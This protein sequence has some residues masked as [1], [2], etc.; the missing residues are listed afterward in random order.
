MAVTSPTHVVSH[1]TA[2]QY[3]SW[4]QRLVAHGSHEFERA[5]PVAQ[6][7][8]AQV[9]APASLGVGGGAVHDCPQI[10]ATSPTQV[11]SQAA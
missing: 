3:G 4:A 8:C 2:Q 5:A 9:L 10:D 1:S 7:G 6:I 11:V